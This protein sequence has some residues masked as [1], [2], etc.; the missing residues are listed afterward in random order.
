MVS[1]KMIQ[2]KVSPEVGDKL[3]TMVKSSLNLKMYWQLFPIHLPCNA[4]TNWPMFLSLIT[5]TVFDIIPWS[6][7]LLSQVFIHPAQHPSWCDPARPNTG[8]ILNYL[9]DVFCLVFFFSFFFI[10]IIV[11]FHYFASTC[12]N[13]SLKYQLISE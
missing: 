8:D 1:V 7:C 4:N 11:L 6:I 10:F 12:H 9:L 3:E 2:N 5:S 13:R